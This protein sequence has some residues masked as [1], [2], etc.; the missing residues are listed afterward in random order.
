[1]E[2]NVNL[3]KTV[4]AAPETSPV[5]SMTA[6]CTSSYLT[7]LSEANCEVPGRGPIAES[8]NPVVPIAVFV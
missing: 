3:S 4:L 6:I 5:V 8:F 7:P 1:M 2:R